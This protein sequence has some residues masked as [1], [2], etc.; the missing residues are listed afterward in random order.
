M[1]LW[2]KRK[3]LQYDNR[4]IIKNSRAVA[5]QCIATGYKRCKEDTNKGPNLRTS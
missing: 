4:I 5:K 2:C 3:E 1:T